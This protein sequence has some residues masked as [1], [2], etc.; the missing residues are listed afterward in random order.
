[1]KT[2]KQKAS[3]TG[4]WLVLLNLPPHLRYL[5]ENVFLV[6]SIP[7]PGKPA[8]DDIN[9]YLEVLVKD[10]LEFWD[11]GIF[12][13]HT[14][15]HHDGKL[16]QA[17]LVPLV[18]DMLGAYQILGLPGVA[19]AHYFCTFCDLDINDLDVLDPAEWPAKDIDHIRH[20]AGMYKHA[21]NEERQQAIFQAFGLQ[22]SMLLDLPYWNPILYT[23]IESMHA[24]DLGLSNTILMS[25]SKS[26]SLS[27]AVMALQRLQLQEISILRMEELFTIASKLYVQMNQVF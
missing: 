10:L 14:F 9:H 13:S 15:N 23:M 16:F 24:L 1:M 27:K 8:T 3:S 6:G 21:P 12:F 2:A 19:T 7:G 18:T 11:P 4:I 5:P 22:W 25:F 26:T 20:V 17:M